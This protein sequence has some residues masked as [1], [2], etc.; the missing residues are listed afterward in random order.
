MFL[1]SM[2]IISS[3]SEKEL[4]TLPIQDATGVKLTESYNK[5]D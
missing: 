5:L 3:G 2:K 4:R 1:V